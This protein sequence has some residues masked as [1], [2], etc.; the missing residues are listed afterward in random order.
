M[1]LLT[2]KEAA[3]YL[4]VSLFTL[5]RIEKQGLLVPFRTPGGHRRYSVQML[6]EYLEQSKSRPAGRQKRV[7]VVDD[8]DELADCLNE[9]LS[10]CRFTTAGDA[11]EVGIKLAE[12]KPDLLLVNTRMS[13]VDGPD[14]CQKL[15]SQGRQVKILPFEGPSEAERVAEGWGF[16]PSR[17][18]TLETRIEGLL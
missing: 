2:A 7:L 12:F 15:D 8:G 10:L 3:K 4:R 14:L 13:G 11:L 16:D 1:K 9:S 18:R 6:N 17:L 5:G